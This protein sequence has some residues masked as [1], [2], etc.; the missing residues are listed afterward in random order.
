MNISEANAVHEVTD[1]LTSLV[2]FEQHPDC[3]V[4]D[5]TLLRAVRFLA[6]RARLALHAGPSAEDVHARMLELLTGDPTLTGGG[7]W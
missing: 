5:A 7:P 4:D 2:L 3:L 1:W 6:E